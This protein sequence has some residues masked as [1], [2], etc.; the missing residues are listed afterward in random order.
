M[1]EQINSCLGQVDVAERDKAPTKDSAHGQSL[2]HFLRLLFR[3]LDENGIRYCVLHTWEGLPDVLPSDLDLAVHPRDRAR[4]SSV[5][6]GLLDKGYQPVQCCHHA[7]GHTFDFV[8]FEARGMRSVSVDVASENRQGRL[9]LMRGEDMVLGRLRAN[10]FWIADPAVEFAYLL[11]KKTLKRRLPNPQA[12]RLKILV[13]EI[14]CAQAQKIAG[15]LFGQ[16]WKERVIE[17]C[18]GGSLGGLLG[19][20]RKRLWLTRLT[21]D[22][23]NPL[24]YLLGE[25]P[26]FIGRSLRPVGLF[27][28]ILG[29]DGVGKSTLVG[30]IGE[31][32]ASTAFRRCRIFHWRPMVIAPQKETG[33]PVTDPH[34]QPPRGV[35]GSILALFGILLDYWLGFIFILRPILTRAGL[36]IFDRYYH[37]L[38]IDP[39]RYRYGGPM[40][41]AKFLGRFVPPPDL[42]FLVLDAGDEVIF[43][44]KREV[45]PE[46][47][48]RQREGYR[49]FTAGVERAT[50]IKTD[51]GI[52]PTV[53]EASRVIVEFLTQRFQRRHARWL[54][55]SC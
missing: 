48:R 10:G 5:F 44:R 30:R 29:P 50:L 52:E 22:P 24:R 45:P 54:A 9:I 13:N 18:K 32:L 38:L 20:L 35:L 34:D 27:V 51:R 46:E 15:D 12:E 33:M 36:V 16:R 1:P 25:V 4:L 37:D 8:W 23:L 2:S 3:L 41:L 49:Q 26:R 19:D 11:V 55:T 7:G 47:L 17:A 28:V 40:W 43:S 42:L 6:Q 31:S 39:L 53:A 14:G 21:K